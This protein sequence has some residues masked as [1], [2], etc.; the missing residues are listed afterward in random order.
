MIQFNDLATQTD[1]AWAISYITDSSGAHAQAV[2]GTNNM[3]P[4]LIRNIATCG[5]DK[6]ITPS[7]RA[8]GNIITGADDLTQFC[9]DNGFLQCVKV[10]FG[11]K[12]KTILKEACWALSNVTAGTKQQVQAV[13]DFGLVPTVIELL[14]HT[15]YKIQKVFR[16]YHFRLS[17]SLLRKLLGQSVIW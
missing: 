11:L 3:V 10:L 15:D 14:R 7:L 17:N 16:Q 13:I 9:L 1:A 2:C 6:L 5:E 12:K 8:V 4:T